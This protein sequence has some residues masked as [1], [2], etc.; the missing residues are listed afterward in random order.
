MSLIVKF[1]DHLKQFGIYLNYL[2][3][4][5][6]PGVYFEAQT[7]G[8]IRPILKYLAHGQNLKSNYKYL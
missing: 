7:M 2:T 3:L 1:H 4:E 5:E 8:K 6:F